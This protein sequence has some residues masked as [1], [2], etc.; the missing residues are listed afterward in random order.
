M[1][2]YA[3]EYGLPWLVGGFAIIYLMIFVDWAF[4]RL[5]STAPATRLAARRAAKTRAWL[6]A[7]EAT[8]TP[9]IIQAERIRWMLNERKRIEAGEHGSH[10]AGVSEP[11]R[12][13]YEQLGEELRR[14]GAL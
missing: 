6:E 12:L 8:R 13:L 5:K 4:N 10:G 9:E 1:R 7:H 2:Y 14:E 11:T 3:P